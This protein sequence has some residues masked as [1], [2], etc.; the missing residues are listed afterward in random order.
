MARRVVVTGMGT[1]NPLGNSVKDFWA[2]A[3]AGENGIDRLSR[4]DVTQ[5]PSRVAGEVKGF[6]PEK[7]L[8]A[9]DARRMDRFTQFVPFGIVRS[10]AP[11][12]LKGR[13][14]GGALLVSSTSTWAM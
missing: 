9:K 8:G 13:P 14:S 5:Y 4:F 3:K 1:V 7:L 12:M 6:A 2:A 10:L 11:M